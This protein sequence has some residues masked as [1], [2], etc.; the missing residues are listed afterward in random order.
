V[1]QV[2]GLLEQALIAELA[3]AIWKQLRLRRLEK[4]HLLTQLERRPSSAELREVGLNA[5]GSAD[6]FLNDP[7]MAD[8]LK[9]V[10]EGRFQANLK[11][12]TLAPNAVKATSM[13]RGLDILLFEWLL[14]YAE[15]SGRLVKTEKMRNL[16]ANEFFAAQ[17]NPVV[18][19]LASGMTEAAA[20][21]LWVLDNTVAIE[22][23]T[24]KVREL[25]LL[26]FMQ[27]EGIQRAQDDLSRSFYR[28]LAELRK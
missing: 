14:A 17:N 27:M 12:F 21:I 13:I 19:L 5:P 3:A 25:R 2:T 15:Q 16:I 23:A 4:H 24:Q 10:T 26:K 11:A 20:S 18:T 1:F 28:T 8:H 22:E 9:A 6:L 7:Q